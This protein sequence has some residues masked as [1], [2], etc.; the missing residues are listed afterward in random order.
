LPLATGR[1]L[2]VTLEVEG[3]PLF[4]GRVGQRQRKRAVEI[5]TVWGAGGDEHA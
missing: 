5:T 2:R 3:R 1:E 4:A